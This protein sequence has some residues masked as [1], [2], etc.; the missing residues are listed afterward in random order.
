[1]KKTILK[2]KKLEVVNF[3]PNENSIKF[4][5]LYDIDN[6]LAELTQESREIVSDYLADQIIKRVK[7]SAD[8]TYETD[9]ILD[10]IQIIRIEDEEDVN[11]KIFNFFEKLRRNALKLKHM[12]SASDY[13]RLYDQLKTEKLTL[14]R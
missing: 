9:N 8:I 1:M 11:E 2:I 6:R 13:M 3:A 14:R 5:V 12:S 4:R 10:S 7:R